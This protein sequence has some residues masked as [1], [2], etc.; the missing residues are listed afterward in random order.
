LG[1]RFTPTGTGTA[2]A[3]LGDFGIDIQDGRK[4]YPSGFTVA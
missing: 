4:F 3:I 2:G 1:L